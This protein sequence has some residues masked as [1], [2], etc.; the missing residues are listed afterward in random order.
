MTLSSCWRWRGIAPLPAAPTQVDAPTRGGCAS[1]PGLA[2]PLS[3][4]STRTPSGSFATTSGGVMGQMDDRQL[5]V[6][7]S[8]GV[9]DS[10][11]TIG[12]HRKPGAKAMDGSHQDC[13]A[14][15]VAVRQVDIEA[16]DLL[17]DLFGGYRSNA[18]AYAKNGKPLFEWRACH[19]V[20]GIALTEMLPYLRIKKLRAENAI[21]VAR[22]NALPNFH[23][24][25]VF[26]DSEGLISVPDAAEVFGKS[27]SSIRRAIREGI[28]PS[29]GRRSDRRLPL[30][31]V[32]MWAE[33]KP[34]G[35]SRSLERTE[36]LE[37]C[38]RRSRELNRVGV[39]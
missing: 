9:I 7:Y 12:I 28:V 35:P 10:D 5:Q 26:D 11:G 8:A 2:A 27:L 33:R 38:W 14:P 25:Y 24:R 22:L 37:H 18:K 4:T 3:P 36:L 34:G 39:L 15:R 16:I 20:A 13:Y 23:P 31:V 29:V 1:V 32:R 17:F 19:Q 21:E 6:A 30:A